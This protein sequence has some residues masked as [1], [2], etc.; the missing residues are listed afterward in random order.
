MNVLWLR[1]TVRHLTALREFIAED[2]PERAELVA[3]RVLKAVELLATHPEIGRPGRL[4][5]TRELVVQN[6]PYV[7]PY[8]I[9]GGRV[10]LLAI[11]H[12]HQKW[13]QTLRG[14]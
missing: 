8:R 1:R 9:R 4:V 6:T 11:L 12:G 14:K 13:P 7:V 3:Q 10:E 2:S 5:G